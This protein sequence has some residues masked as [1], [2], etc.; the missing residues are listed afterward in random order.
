MGISTFNTTLKFRIANLDF[1]GFDEG[2]ILTGFSFFKL[3]LSGKCPIA[4]CL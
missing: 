1:T 2:F 4:D 3:R